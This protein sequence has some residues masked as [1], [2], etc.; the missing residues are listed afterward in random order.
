MSKKVTVYDIAKELGISPS[1]V[2]RVLNN[3]SLI[4]DAKR[5]L[6]LSTAERMEYKKRP[7][8]KQKGRAIINIR[9]FLPPAKYSYIHLFYDIAELL[10]GI[11]RGF[12]DTRINVITSINDG[13]VSLFDSKKLGDIDGSIFAF[14]EP[15]P[16]LEELLE[17][18]NIPFILLNRSHPEH[19]YVIVDS[20]SGMDHLIEALYRRK[21]DSLNPC[22]IGFSP[23]SQVSSQREKGVLLA[24]EKRG[25]EFS[26]SNIINIDSIGELRE[27]VLP[28]IKEHSYNAVLCFNDM[29]AVSVYQSIL[30]Q[31]KKIP[32]YFSLTGFDNSPILDLLD[33]RIDTVEFSLTKLGKEAGTWLSKRII[34]RD[35]SPLQK[36]LE[37]IYIPGETI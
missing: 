9:L 37:G 26:E 13:D 16:Q 10:S 21:K 36:A 6:I 11:Q 19:N 35:E 8:K 31:G 25:I 2:S 18:R 28:T 20:L 32:D 17:E 27:T 15:S 1:T 7:I 23:L 33:Q 12:G 22:Y 5:D 30:H 24:C 14:T 34:D 4:G 29:L 3:S